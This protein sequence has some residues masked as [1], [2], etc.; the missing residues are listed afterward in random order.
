MRLKKYRQFKQNMQLKKYRQLK[1]NRQLKST[2]SSS[3]I[4]S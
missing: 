3:R 2:G 1:Q 4:G